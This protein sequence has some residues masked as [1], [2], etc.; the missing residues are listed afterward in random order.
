RHPGHHFGEGKVAATASHFPDSFVRLL[1]N[2]LK[3]LDQ[4]LLQRPGRADGSEAKHPSLMQGIDQLAV[5]VELKLIGSRISN[6]HRR[7]T[8]VAGQPRHLPPAAS[9]RPPKTLT[10]F[11]VEGAS[12]PPC[13]GATAPTPEPHRGSLR[14]QAP[15]T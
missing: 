15:S 5:D 11:G 14:I 12:P 2:L 10:V 8:A 3:M 13:A 4:F 7:S 1:P 9:R 6:A